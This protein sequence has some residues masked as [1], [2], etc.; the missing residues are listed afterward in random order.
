MAV[1]E[2]AYPL[3]SRSSVSS[4]AK[5]AGEMEHLHSR[6]SLSGATQTSQPRQ[7]KPNVA[8]FLIHIGLVSDS[9]FRGPR[10]TVLAKV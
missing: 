2:F 10:P 6:L 9:D 7:S 3:I 1:F 5:T 8:G 4:I